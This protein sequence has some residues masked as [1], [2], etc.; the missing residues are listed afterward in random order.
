[1]VSLP[2]YVLPWLPC[3]VHKLK[4]LMQHYMCPARGSTGWTAM[5]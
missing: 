4:E 3:L 2:F 5:C 1:M